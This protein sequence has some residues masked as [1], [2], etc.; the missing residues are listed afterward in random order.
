MKVIEAKLQAKPGW[1]PAACEHLRAKADEQIKK[2]ADLHAEYV[3]M[4]LLVSAEKVTDE[5]VSQFNKQVE[6]LDA[7]VARI[8]QGYKDFVKK[9]LGDFIKYK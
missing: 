9:D 8:E 1:G 5:S 2:A 4:S 7:T 3:L 6:V